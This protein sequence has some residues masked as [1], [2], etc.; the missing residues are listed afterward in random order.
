MW[1]IETKINI[2]AGSLSISW[3]NSRLIVA[4]VA[5]RDA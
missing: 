5:R 1:H 3:V 2:K 4:L